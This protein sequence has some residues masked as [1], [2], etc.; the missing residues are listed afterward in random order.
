LLPT[1][2]IHPTIAAVAAE[3][4]ALNARIGRYTNFVNLLDL[5]AVAVPAGFRT[6]GLPFG[7]SLVAPAFCDEALADLG[8]RLHRRLDLPLGGTPHFIGG[9]NAP[10]NDH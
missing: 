1:S 3:P 6:C 10:L 5:T 7:V 4:F 2:P 8:G 9:E